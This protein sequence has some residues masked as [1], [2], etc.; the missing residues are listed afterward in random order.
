[1][2]RKIVYIILSVL[3]LGLGIFSWLFFF[4]VDLVITGFKKEVIVPVFSENI[5]HD[6]NICYGTL[7]KCDNIEITPSLVVDYNKVGDYTVNYLYSY[8]DKNDV[9]TQVV[10]VVDDEKPVI[11]IDSPIKVCPNGKILDGKYSALDNYD[12]DLTSEVKFLE[13]SGKNYLEVSDNSG[14]HTLLSS[15]TIN[16]KDDVA[17]EI[18]LSG[19]KVYLVV[20]KKYSEPG[21][22]A[23]DSCDGDL[24]SKVT[25]K[26]N[27]NNQKTGTYEV[28]YSVKDSSGNLKSV[29]RKVQVIKKNVVVNPTNKTIYLTFDDGPC[30]YTGKLLNIL[31]EYNVKATF[32]VT[33]QFPSYQKYIK[34]AYQRGHSIGVH[35]YSHNFNIYRSVETYFND[36]NKMNAIIKKQTGSESRIIRF[37]GGSSN[38][39]SRSYSKGIMKTLANELEARGYSYFDW[40]LGSGDTDGLNT[41]SKVAN[42]VIK[43]LGNQTRMVLMHDIKSYSVDAVRDIIEYGLSHGYNFQSININSPTYHHKI[44]N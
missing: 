33:N 23:S 39:V 18:T 11:T 24:T 28:V 37:P 12:G 13:E 30:A 7:F 15:D 35:T 29:V 8:G 1:M 14:N 20:G 42:N 36:L 19:G 21:Y 25:V 6:F 22:K 17:P 32:F 9:L 43:K 3:C 31:D 40:N 4:K 44:N 2:Y 38:T 41:S 26:N 10:R 5:E 34:E 27:V 16:V